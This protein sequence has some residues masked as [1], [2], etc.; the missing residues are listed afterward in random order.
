MSSAPTEINRAR[1]GHSLRHRSRRRVTDQPCT[2]A[3]LAVPEPHVAVIVILLVVQASASQTHPPWSRAMRRAILFVVVCLVGACS[4]P[5]PDAAD[6]RDSTPPAAAPDTL[7]ATALRDSAKATLATLLDKPEAATFDSV[8]VVQPPRQGERLTAM[9]VCGRIDGPAGTKL[10]T[11]PARFVFQS[12]WALFVE[13]DTNRDEFAK[14]WE[15][16]CAAT[17]ATVVVR[18]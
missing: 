2:S 8:V 1:L 6:R 3:L 5:A 11:P 7:A 13:D 12:K 15:S 16:R 10:R 14:L 17:G 18:G 9:A 4:A